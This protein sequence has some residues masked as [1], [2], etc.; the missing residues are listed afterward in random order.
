MSVYIYRDMK[1]ERERA[2]YL[3][4]KMRSFKRA[5]GFNALEYI[6]PIFSV[7]RLVW[8]KRHDVYYHPS[9]MC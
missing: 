5:H 8:G 2:T 6:P 9:V 4:C 7:E 3:H 1:R